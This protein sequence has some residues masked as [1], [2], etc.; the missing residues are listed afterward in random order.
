MSE[1]IDVSTGPDNTVT[2]TLT[3]DQAL[4]VANLIG[5]GLVERTREYV[6]SPSYQLLGLIGQQAR[7]DHVWL[8]TSE[9][10]VE[11]VQVLTTAANAAAKARATTD[12]VA[13]MYCGENH[14]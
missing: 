13:C 6:A 3:P 12:Y 2:V 8:N 14:G 1:A 9:E 7:A 11:L 4:T 5:E 10:Y